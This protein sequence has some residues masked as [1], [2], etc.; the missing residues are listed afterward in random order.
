MKF[1]MLGLLVV[2][3]GLWWMH[4]GQKQATDRT[5]KRLVQSGKVA[6]THPTITN[7]QVKTPKGEVLYDQKAGINRLPEGS[8]PLLE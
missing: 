4:S 3:G 7:V 2:A 5:F 1:L 6:R 8:K